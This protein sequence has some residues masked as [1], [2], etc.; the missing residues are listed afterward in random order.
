MHLQIPGFSVTEYDEVWDNTVILP[1]SRFSN[2]HQSPRPWKR[3]ERQGADAEEDSSECPAPAPAGDRA[4][5]EVTRAVRCS[6]WYRPAQGSSA[7][8]THWH[9][10]F[11]LY[12]VSCT[13]YPVPCI[14]YPVPCTLYPV[15]CTLYPVP[16]ASIFRQKG[17]QIMLSFELIPMQTILVQHFLNFVSC[18]YLSF[19]C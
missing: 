14:L 18:R 10:W 8:R 11:I 1:Y 12:S 19:G 7:I 9:R 13:F 17:L 2:S 5:G 6:H 3:A 15:P 4:A 16:G